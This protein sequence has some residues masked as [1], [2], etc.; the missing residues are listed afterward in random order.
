MNLLTFLNNLLI[1]LN[2]DAI[3]KAL[4]VWEEGCNYCK[5]I[6]QWLEHDITEKHTATIVKSKT[7]LYLKNGGYVKRMETLFLRVMSV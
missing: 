5:L 6:I 2:N 1:N 7:P 4:G 3:Q